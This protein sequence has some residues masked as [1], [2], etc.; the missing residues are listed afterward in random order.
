MI[1]KIRKAIDVL[2]KKI[3]IFLF[4]LA[5]VVVMI[6]FVDDENRGGVVKFGNMLTD[7]FKKF[8]EE[9]NC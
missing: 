1:K 2:E 9:D 5:Y 7:V 4:Q 6:E 8:L 3:K